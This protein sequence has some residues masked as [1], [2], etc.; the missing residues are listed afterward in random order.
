MMTR[1]EGRGKLVEVGCMQGGKKR[2][3]KEK[4]KK[5]RKKEEE[6]GLTR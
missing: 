3:R 2:T 1:Q 5:K 4:D 6:G